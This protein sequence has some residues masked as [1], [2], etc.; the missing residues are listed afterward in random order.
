MFE[1]D[2]A[3][4]AEADG[5]TNESKKPAPNTEGAPSEKNGA[6]QFEGVSVLLAEDA[7]DLQYLFRKMLEAVG[8]KVTVVSNGVEAVEK[9]LAEEFDLILMDVRMPLL[10]GNEATL[11][12]RNKHCEIPII[13]LTA[14]A[15]KETKDLSSSIGYDDFITKPPTEQDLL[16]IIAKWRRKKP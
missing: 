8:C 9:A 1:I 14:Y 6:Q 16:N 15:M 7:I 11:Q 5:K 12:L 4:D 10:G 2:I 3:L 13:A